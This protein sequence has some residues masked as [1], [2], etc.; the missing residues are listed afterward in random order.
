MPLIVNSRPTPRLSQADA[1]HRVCEHGLRFLFFTDPDT[2]SGQ[3]LYLRY[4]GNLGL[5][6]PIGEDNPDGTS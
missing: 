4:D 5:L 2:F 3:L 1:V 6:T